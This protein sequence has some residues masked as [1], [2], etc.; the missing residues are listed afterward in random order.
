MSPFPRLS[1]IIVIIVPSRWEV[2]H[3]NVVEEGTI[4]LTGYNKHNSC[5]N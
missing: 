5:Q 2:I 3:E 4:I 1:N